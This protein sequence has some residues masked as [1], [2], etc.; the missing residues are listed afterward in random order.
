MME[1]KDTREVVVANL[2]MRV[3]INSGLIGASYLTS[4]DKVRAEFCTDSQRGCF[5]FRSGPKESDG[6][7][8][9]AVADDKIPEN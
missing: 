2:R 5:P 3:V 6:M 4:A 1:D 8:G 9:G 7:R